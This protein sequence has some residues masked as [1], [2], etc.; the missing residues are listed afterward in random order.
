MTANTS[1]TNSQTNSVNPPGYVDLTN[2]NPG[3][4]GKPL[5]LNNIFELLVSMI[6]VLQRTA[7]AQAN[8]LN[9]LSNWQKAYT[10]EMNQIHSFVAANGDAAVTEN[11][12]NNTEVIPSSVN[13]MSWTIG[14][15][16]S[17]S[18][19]AGAI[20]QDLNSA[21][22]TYTQEMQGNNNVISNDAKSLQT[23]VNQTNDAVQSQTDMATSILQQLSTILTSIYQ[24]AG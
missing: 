16:D 13:A 6:Q 20:R 21:N 15:L 8:Q 14:G 3:H 23:N 2:D 11:N 12:R 5:I 18:A 17:T 19:D 24:A 9:F 7:A 4:F 10:D 22:T 1:Q